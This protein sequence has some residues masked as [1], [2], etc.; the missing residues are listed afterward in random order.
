M[1]SL[2]AF[3]LFLCCTTKVPFFFFKRKVE[4]KERELSAHLD[5][6]FREELFRQTG[7]MPPEDFVIEG[8]DDQVHQVRQMFSAREKTTIQAEHRS[9]SSLLSQMRS[10]DIRPIQE[11][12]KRAI[13][14]AV[15]DSIDQ[16][17]IH[18]EEW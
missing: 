8:L 7:K 9:L 16:N 17:M 11:Q 12:V 3:S 4:E 18:P 14:E 5:G 2:P 1:E 10:K 15:K 6:M 13:A